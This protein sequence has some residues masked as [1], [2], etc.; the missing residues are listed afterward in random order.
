[1]FGICPTLFHKSNRRAQFIYDYMIGKGVPKENTRWRGYG[2]SQ[3]V[4][5]EDR[6]KKAKTKEEQES[7]YQQNLHTEF[8]IIAITK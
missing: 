5:P 4:I 2:E 8:K 3:P 6:I 7:L 1:M